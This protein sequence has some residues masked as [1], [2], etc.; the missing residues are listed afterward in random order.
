MQSICKKRNVPQ[1]SHQALY[2]QTLIGDKISI[3][4]CRFDPSTACLTDGLLTLSKEDGLRHFFK[5]I[6]TG[7]NLL[8][9]LTNKIN[10]A[11]LTGNTYLKLRDLTDQ[12]TFKD[13][14]DNTPQITRNGVIELLVEVGLLE[15]VGFIGPTCS[16]SDLGG[17]VD[18]E[19][20]SD[21]EADTPKIKRQRDKM[22]TQ[23][24]KRQ[25]TRTGHQNGAI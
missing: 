15:E 21:D 24:T 13:D 18:D 7:E 17:L 11:V 1:L 4:L 6:L 22:D 23:K 14:E 20:D 10:L 16:S 3:P 19:T 25:R 9:E 12:W 2:L 5:Y 8:K